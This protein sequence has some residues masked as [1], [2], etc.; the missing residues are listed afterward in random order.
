[1][2]ARSFNRY[3]LCF[4]FIALLL[5]CSLSSAD[6]LRIV[7]LGDSITQGQTSRGADGG[8]TFRYWLWK[9][10]IDA[11]VD[12]DFVG[13]MDSAYGGSGDPGW[14][15]YN[16]HAFDRDHEGHWGWS[17]EMIRNNLETWLQGYTADVALVHIGHNDMWRGVSNPTIGYGATDAYLRDMIHRLQADNPKI[18][19]LLARVVPA[20]E[21]STSFPPIHLDNLNALLDAIATEETTADSRIHIVDLHHEFDVDAWIYDEVHPNALG[22]RFMARLWFHA[23]Q[24]HGVIPAW[25]T[26]FSQAA[27][28]FHGTGSGQ[29]DRVR[30][31]IDDN[32]PGSLNQSPC[33][34]GQQGFTL[35]FWL[36]GDLADNDTSNSGGDVETASSSWREGN[37]IVDRHIATGSGAAWGVSVAGGFIRFGTGQG[38]DGSDPENTIEGNQ[39]VL[40]NRWHHVAIVRD[41]ATGHKRIYVDGLLDFESSAGVSFADLSYPDGG[42][43]GQDD[44]PILVLGAEKY[45]EGPAYPSFSG[46]F[47]ELRIW[48]DARTAHQVMASHDKVLPAYWPGIVACYRFEEGEGTTIQDASIAG[49]FTGN[50]TAGI[51]GN[52]EWVKAEDDRFNAAPVR[53][54]WPTL[55]DRSILKM[56]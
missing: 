44:G 13:S 55:P 46:F 18:T 49:S 31:P 9:K 11:K 52:G 5:S 38:A 35:D 37:V 22:E 48:D 50:L 54:L 3:S 42:V 17:T 29:Q 43:A 56:N 28:R 10:L 27:L 41:I 40:D 32:D 47:D 24:T 23:L 34:V 4:V 20:P 25:R 15:D 51:V 8:Y 7:C 21:W 45:D 14:P 19:I 16:G 26:H 39:N 36:R 1:M 12:F 33:D 2:L 53:P 6:T 30:I